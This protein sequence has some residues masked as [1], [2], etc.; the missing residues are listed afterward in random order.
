MR[1][2][3]NAFAIQSALD[4]ARRSGLF[5]QWRCLEAAWARRHIIVLMTVLMA[6]S[7]AVDAAAQGACEGPATVSPS[8]PTN[9]T[10]VTLSFVGLADFDGCSPITYQVAGGVVTVLNE[11]VLRF[12]AR[13]GE[14]RGQH[15]TPC[16]RYV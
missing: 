6:V 5:E 3:R 11:W 7:V 14:P 16:A 15:R 4:D 9:Q 12:F 2:D 13:P 8:N 10:T 1:S